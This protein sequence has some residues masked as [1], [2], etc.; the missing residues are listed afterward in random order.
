MKANTVSPFELF[1]H[2]IRYVVPMFQRPYVWTKENQWAPLWEDIRTL[3]ERLLESPGQP[4][5]P[6][7]MG[8]VVVEQQPLHDVTFTPIWHV[9]DGQQRLTT[10][11]LLLDAAQL[12][13]QNHAD[14]TDASALAM[15]VA[16]NTAVLRHPDEVFKVWPSLPDQEAFRAVMHDELSP[17]AELEGARPCQAHA[18]F[19]SEITEWAETTG[20]PE[21]VRARLHALALALMNHLKVVAIDLD[22]GDN[23]QVIFETLNHRGTPLLAGDLVKNLVFQLAE[24]QDA[25]VQSLYDDYWA[26]FDT[27]AWRRNVKQGRLYRPQIDVFLNYWLVTKLLREVPSDRVFA[28]FRD[29][30]RAEPMPVAGLLRELRGKAGVYESL[31]RWSWDSVEG[32]FVYRMLRIMEQFAFGPLL[33]VLL[34]WSE[35]EFAPAE[36]RKALQAIESWSVR[37]MLC[38]LTTKQV[39]TLVIDLVG[40]LDEA[41]PAGASTTVIKFFSGQGAESRRWPDDAEVAEAL[42][43]QPL[44]QVLKRDRLRMVLEAVEDSLRTPLSDEQRCKRGAY[45]IEHVMPQGWREHW[46]AGLPDAHDEIAAARRDQHIHTL[47]N[48]TLVNNRLNPT[49]SNRPWTD[50]EAIARGLPAIDG[51]H[52]KRS[53]LQQNLTLH[54]NKHVVIDH[55][56]AWTDASI[57]ERVERLIPHVHKVWP[58]ATAFGA[59][60]P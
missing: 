34:G 33:L 20:D 54:L 48:L 32:T 13:M 22:P 56:D 45:T 50:E 52:G 3:T 31:E 60:P 39:N 10:L 24:K 59:P 25:P 12:V 35:E 55:P 58:S 17:T 19:V 51:C 21:K 5:P 18:F 1:G 47:G 27:E 57:D 30:A 15:L 40:Q 4:V 29:L 9:I 37:R 28:D 7:F 46:G 42:R 49:L 16:N 2:Q 38:R 26:P 41:G 14:P 43:T 44:Y 23:A 53:I 11:Q 8:A 6:H 36:R